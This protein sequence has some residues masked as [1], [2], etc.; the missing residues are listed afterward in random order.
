[1]LTRLRKRTA[2][3]DAAGPLM[4]KVKRED[5]PADARLQRPAIKTELADEKPALPPP[6]PK[7]DGG[8]LFIKTL[9]GST[10][11]VE[12]LSFATDSIDDVVM[13]IYDKTNYPRDLQRLIFRGKQ[14]ER[15]NLLSTYGIRKEE[16]LHLVLRLRGGMLH[17]T[18]GR[19][20][21]EHL[22]STRGQYRIGVM[23]LSELNQHAR[24][25]VPVD[26]PN[27]LMLSARTDLV[28]IGCMVTPVSAKLGIPVDQLEFVFRGK[29]LSRSETFRS[30][31]IPGGSLLYATR[32]EFVRSNGGHPDISAWFK[33]TS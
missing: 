12:I 24:S 29:V 33:R 28:S 5:D 2:N 4:K 13:K 30:Y 32:K 27:A 23:P 1:M 10:I 16:T 26:S 20:N 7:H 15:G 14:L 31:D 6:P 8:Q 9:T 17:E 22:A 19:E 3:Q 21:F 25:R 18:S 11:T